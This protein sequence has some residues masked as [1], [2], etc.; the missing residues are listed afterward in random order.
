MALKPLAFT[1]NSRMFLC[2]RVAKSTQSFAQILPE[3][4]YCEK[5]TCDMLVVKLSYLSLTIRMKTAT[6][7]QEPGNHRTKRESVKRAQ[8]IPQHKSAIFK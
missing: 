3:Q 6:P 2:E 7:T 1:I 5:K 8:E 4:V